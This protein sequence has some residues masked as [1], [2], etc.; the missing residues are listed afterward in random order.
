MQE[1]E[2]DLSQALLTTHTRNHFIYSLDMDLG[3][4][5]LFL[6]FVCFPCFRHIDIYEEGIW[7]HSL[8]TIL[9]VF[10]LPG[11]P[12]KSC[13]LTFS[14]LMLLESSSLK[15]LLLPLMSVITPP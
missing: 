2:E 8:G 7:T 15:P 11:L 3:H 12:K 9:V 14:R 6:S 4:Q 13:P 10:P 1:I 5:T